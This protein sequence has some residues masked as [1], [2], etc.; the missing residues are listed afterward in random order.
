MRV[1]LSETQKVSSMALGLRQTTGNHGSLSH[2]PRFNTAAMAEAAWRNGYHKRDKA[3]G[4][5]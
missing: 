2:S 3:N 5:Q 1:F 4:A